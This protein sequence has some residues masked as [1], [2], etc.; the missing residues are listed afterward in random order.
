ME[1]PFDKEESD[2]FGSIYRPHAQVYFWSKKR[3]NWSGA[4]MIIDSGADYTLLPRNY[5]EELGIIKGLDTTTLSTF[6]V[7][8]GSKVYLLKDKIRVKL[9]KWERHIPV[10]FLESNDVP[11]LLG[12]HEFMETFKI[13]FDRRITY[14][15]SKS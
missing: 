6:G 10:G 9:G 12:R 14:I 4:V 2:L 8:G 5:M 13:T 11:P 1:L 7:G 15:D 3:R